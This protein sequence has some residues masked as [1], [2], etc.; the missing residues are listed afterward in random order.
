VRGKAA[1]G[2]GKAEPA[3][4]GAT[5]VAT[6]IAAATLFSLGGEAETGL[7]LGKRTRDDGFAHKSIEDTS[8]PYPTRGQTSAW[9]RFRAGWTC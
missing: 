6:I 3:S 1:A 7:S 4:E 2:L 5:T 9:A 8:L